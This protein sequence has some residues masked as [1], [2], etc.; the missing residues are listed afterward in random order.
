M[1]KLAQ[2]VTDELLTWL[3]CLILGFAY[4]AVPY[5]PLLLISLA[6]DGTMRPAIWCVFAGM[7]AIIV[8]ISGGG[9]AD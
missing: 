7:M 8:R 1:T 6:I 9:H 2:R 3:V 5:M 4:G